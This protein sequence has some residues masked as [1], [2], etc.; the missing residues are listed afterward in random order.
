MFDFFT[1]EDEDGPEVYCAFSVIHA[2]YSWLFSGE[3]ID[4]YPVDFDLTACITWRW[5]HLL[6]R[7][8]PPLLKT[9]VERHEEVFAAIE[10]FAHELKSEERV[11]EKWRTKEWPTNSLKNTLR[12]ARALRHVS[13]IFAEQWP[14]FVEYWPSVLKWPPEQIPTPPPDWWPELPKPRRKKAKPSE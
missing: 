3:D 13:P 5:K 4:N 12:I 10:G 7:L 6:P 14:A 1:Y 9:F 2:G 8:D 11:I